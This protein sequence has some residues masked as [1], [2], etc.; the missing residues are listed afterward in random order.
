MYPAAI[1]QTLSLLA[2]KKEERKKKKQNKKT[3]ERSLGYSIFFTLSILDIGLK[4]RQPLNKEKQITS[5]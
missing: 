1:L 2:L 4:G 3:D 5:V